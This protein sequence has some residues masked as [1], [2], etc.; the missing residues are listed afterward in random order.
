M[1]TEEALDASITLGSQLPKS[2]STPVKS[3]KPAMLHE[4]KKISTHPFN[5]F[6]NIDQVQLSI[7]CHVNSVK[8]LVCVPGMT[9][10]DLSKSS[11][12]KMYVYYNIGLGTFHKLILAYFY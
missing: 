7:H 5:P 1:R 4:S 6:C 2:S 10:S 12:S 9:P 3:D 8:S 11:S